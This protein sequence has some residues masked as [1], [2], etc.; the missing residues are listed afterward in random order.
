MELSDL[1]TRRINECF[2]NSEWKPID[3]NRAIEIMKYVY[4][5]C[6]AHGELYHT[7]NNSVYFRDLPR[8]IS[9]KFIVKDWSLENKAYFLNII[10]EKYNIDGFSYYSLGVN[11]SSGKLEASE[12]D[13]GYNISFSI[14]Q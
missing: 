6:D 1:V 3:A 9:I 13:Y 4:N 10:Q 14:K 11:H 8:Q 7:K 12:N 2:W 5:N